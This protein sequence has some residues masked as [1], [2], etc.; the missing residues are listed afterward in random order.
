MRDRIE[1]VIETRAGVSQAW[2]S[3]ATPEGLSVW[4]SDRVEGKWAVGEECVLVWGEHRSRIRILAIDEP[5]RFAY[6]WVPGVA[7]DVLPAGH[8]TTVEFTLTANP[9]GG[10]TIRLVE[11]GFAALPEEFYEEAFRNNDEG[12]T[13]ELAKLE[14]LLAA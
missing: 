12:W 2:K 14:A 11:S 8:T 4:F 3:F 5:T 1:R 10:S 7:S 13:E 9:D 6:E